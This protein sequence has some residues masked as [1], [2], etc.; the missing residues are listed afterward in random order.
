MGDSDELVHVAIKVHSVGVRSLA[1][2]AG[3]GFPGHGGHKRAAG[4]RSFLLDPP[5]QAV[6]VHVPH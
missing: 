1:E 2:L 3:E 5:A 4:D 6:Q